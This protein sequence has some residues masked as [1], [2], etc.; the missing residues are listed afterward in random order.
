MHAG[1]QRAKPFYGWIVV[2]AAFVVTF[3]GFG[4]DGGN[5]YWLIRNSIPFHVTMGE[6]IHC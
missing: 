4:S 1:Y 2:A 3:I 6:E 5:D